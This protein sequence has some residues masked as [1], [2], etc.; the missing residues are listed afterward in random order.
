MSFYQ[1]GGF[2]I[3]PQIVKNLLIINGLFFLATIVLDSSFGIDLVEKLGLYYFGSD[4]FKPYQFVSHLFLHGGFFH[5]FSNMLALWMFGNAL[6]NFWGP[7]KFLTYYLITGLGAATLHT[8]VT[9]YDVYKLETG[10]KTFVESPNIDTFSEFVQNHVPGHYNNTFI[11]ILNAWEE[12][13][14]SNDIKN[15]AISRSEE[16]LEI[17]KNIPTVG[18]SGAVFGVLLAYGMLFPNTIIY[19]N[20]F[21]PIKAKYFVAIYGLFELYAGLQN[22]A[23]DNVAHFAHLGGMIFGFILIRL[24]SKRNN[25][26]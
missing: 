8:T 16:M 20:L 23:G 4:F 22:N 11:Q 17:K 3:L 21:F 13:P 26:F 10:V 14:E 9:A 6:E 5:L 2:N 24:W 25:T 15:I 18:A 12:N 1:P 19:F 7:K